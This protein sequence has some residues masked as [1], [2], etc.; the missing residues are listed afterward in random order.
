MQNNIEITIKP[1]RAPEFKL[2]QNVSGLDTE[3]YLHAARS[4]AEI[5]SDDSI[6]IETMTD[7]PED[8]PT[9][10]VTSSLGVLT[11]SGITGLV[12]DREY[13][14]DDGGYLAQIVTLDI[15]EWRAQYPEEEL[16]GSTHDILDFGVWSPDLKYDGPAEDWRDE[17]DE[18]RGE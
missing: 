5:S 3:D 6:Y 13:V 16:I 14:T 9:F 7:L 1:D 10:L 4:I 8:Y 2:G 18:L 11:V 15:A 17:R 12:L